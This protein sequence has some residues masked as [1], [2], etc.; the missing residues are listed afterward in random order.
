[1]C[2]QQESHEL[3]RL[4]PHMST[5]LDTIVEYK[6]KEVEKNKQVQSIVSLEQTIK[7][8]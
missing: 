4:E 3:I 5:I 8:G 7:S 6:K 2:S 1:M